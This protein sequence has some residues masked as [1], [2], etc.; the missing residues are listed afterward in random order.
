L[1]YGDAFPDQ[2]EGEEHGRLVTRD[3]GSIIA[4]PYVKK[5]K[6]RAPVM[7][8]GRMIHRP[9]G[10]TVQEPYVKKTRT[11]TW[12]F[13]PSKSG[14]TWVFYPNGKSQGRVFR[15]YQT[16]KKPGGEPDEAYNPKRLGRPAMSGLPPPQQ[17]EIDQMPPGQF[18]QGPPP[19]DQGGYGSGEG[20]IFTEVL[21]GGRPMRPPMRR[22]TGDIAQDSINNAIDNFLSFG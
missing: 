12:V 1:S 13:Y 11:G 3:D 17:A 8:S 21:G 15:P 22:Q 4:Q 2:E 20:T 16:K 10:S 18:D 5:V 19:L 7:D 9:D 14:G 6:T